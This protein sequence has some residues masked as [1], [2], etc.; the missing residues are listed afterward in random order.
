MY[1]F[2]ISADQLAKLVVVSR[3]DSTN[4]TGMQRY[5]LPKKVLA[6]AKY[7]SRSDTLLP[8]NIIV[9]LTQQV[10]FI[11]S[12]A[13]SSVGEIIFPQ[14]S[15]EFGYILDGQHRLAGIVSEE[16]NQH[17]LEV[18][19]TALILD[20]S[21]QAAQVFSDIN[22]NQT[23][24]SKVLLVSLQRELGSLPRPQDLAAALVEKLDSDEDSP[25]FGRIQMYPDE[26][27]R[28]LTNAQAI[29]II[30]RLTQPSK[31]LSRFTTENATEY[32]KRYFRAFAVVFNDSW[33]NRTYKLTS[34]AGIDVMVGLF[35]RVLEIARDTSNERLPTEDDFISALEP[36]KNTDWSSETFRNMG[37]T[38]SGGRIRLTNN[39]L[40]KLPPPGADN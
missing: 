6:I 5:L 16:S 2:S 4:P 33:G 38:S 20:N 10:K 29:N 39:L 21:N 17:S 7:I 36:I 40:E 34:P 28:W 31:T 13:T 1:L 9:S 35:E 25:F 30:S 22:S 14:E 3:R 24:I 26:K 32:L 23:P 11:P 19:V 27:N 37:Y 18:P 15:G 12:S 8:N